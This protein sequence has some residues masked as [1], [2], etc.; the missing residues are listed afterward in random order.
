MILANKFIKSS[1]YSGSLHKMHLRKSLIINQWRDLFVQLRVHAHTCTVRVGGRRTCGGWGHT[2]HC[3]ALARYCEF[4]HCAPRTHDSDRPSLEHPTLLMEKGGDHLCEGFLQLHA[5]FLCPFESGSVR[6]ARVI[7]M[8]MMK[9]G[10]LWAA[11]LMVLWSRG[12]NRIRIASARA[13]SHR[14]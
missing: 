14:L 2:G 1:I 13:N 5:H 4:G 12:S 10:V 6:F 8:G 7:R 11:K 3:L 9:V